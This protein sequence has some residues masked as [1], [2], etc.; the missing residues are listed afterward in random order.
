VMVPVCDQ[1]PLV[2][3]L[4]CL[5]KVMGRLQH[6]FGICMHWLSPGHLYMQGLLCLCKTTC[7]LAEAQQILHVKMPWCKHC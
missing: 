2:P 3:V 6:A 7:D 4:T 1:A 5:A